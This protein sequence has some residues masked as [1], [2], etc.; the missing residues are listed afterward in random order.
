MQVAIDGPASSGK[1]TIA[2]IVAKKLGFIY[3]DTGA[4]YRAATW[5]ALRDHINLDDASDLLKA[6]DDVTIRFEPTDDGQLVFIND[7]DITHAIREPDV[8]NN[9]SQVSALA[10]IRTEMVKRQQQIAEEG[11][12]VMDGRDIGTTVLPHAQVKI[13]MTA[14]AEERAK[15]R[16]A[17]NIAKGIMTPLSQLQDEIVARDHKDSTRKI[18]PLRK[19]DDAIEIDTTHLGID[20]VVA[21]ILEIIQTVQNK[22]D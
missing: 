3:C 17:E 22:N 12:I 21:Q 18:S 8:T 2:K 13:F 5:L 11:N 15:R 4:M 1:S 7:I 6:L 20:E 14:S 10:P 9:V 16:Y 19:A